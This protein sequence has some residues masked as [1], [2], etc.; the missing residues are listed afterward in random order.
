[1]RPPSLIGE[2]NSIQGEF[3]DFNDYLV[4][5]LSILLSFMGYT[6]L[7]AVL[8]PT[9]YWCLFVARRPHRI[10]GYAHFIPEDLQ[11]NWAGNF[12]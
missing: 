10:Q 6:C 5:V 9:L 7:L 12:R 11:K 1:V 2:D 8:T 3:M 4:L